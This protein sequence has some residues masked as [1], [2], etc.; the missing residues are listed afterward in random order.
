MLSRQRLRSWTSRQRH[1]NRSPTPEW[2]RSPLPSGA[3]GR[4]AAVVHTYIGLSGNAGSRAP[5]VQ[6]ELALA[7]PERAAALA[8]DHTSAAHWAG[9]RTS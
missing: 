6:V 1:P 2:Q 4:R 8:V 7:S 5:A 3:P 9:A